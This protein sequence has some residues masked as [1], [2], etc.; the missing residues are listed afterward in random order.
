MRWI[1]LITYLLLIV[2]LAMASPENY[3]NYSSITVKVDYTSSIT[4]TSGDLN[5]LKANL[6]FFPIAEGSQ[7][8]TSFETIS[9]PVAK[10]TRED[11][12]IL[13]F[14]EENAPNF[15]YGYSTVLESKSEVIKIKNKVPYPQDVDESVAQYTLPSEFIDITSEMEDI[16]DEIIGSEDDLYKVV[17]LLAEWTRQNIEYDLTTLTADAVQKSSWVLENR[18]GV[19][20]ELTNLFISLARSRGIPARFT[21]G[22]VY[23]NSLYDFGPHGWAEVYIDDKWVPVDVTFG[24]MG[25]NDPDHIYF[26]EEVDSGESAVLYEWNGD[27]KIETSAPVINGEVLSTGKKVDYF[28]DFQIEPLLNGVGPGSY[29]PIQVT[30]ENPYDYYLPIKFSVTKAPGLVDDN[31]KIVL[32][33]PFEKTTVYWI[34][35]ISA[36]TEENYIYTTNVEIRTMLGEVENTTIT[37]GNKFGYSSLSEAESLVN[38]LVIEGS[39]SFLQNVGLVCNLDKDIYYS[40]ETALLSCDLQGHIDNISVCFRGDCKNEGSVLEWE[41]DLLNFKSQKLLIIAQKGKEILPEYIDLRIISYPEVSVVTVNPLSL[42]FQ[43]VVDLQ[44]ELL[45]TAPVYDVEVLLENYGVINIGEF[46]GSYIL[47]VPA[48]GKNFPYGKIILDISYSDELGKVYQ[49]NNVH[50]LEIT[51]IPIYYRII[52]WLL[53][54][55]SG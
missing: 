34:T 32:L 3:N 7:T 38:D 46:S 53:S 14:W 31:V 44:I 39:N 19:C 5:Y 8:I 20:D 37:Y 2:P 45:A 42:D 52:Y 48:S 12:S 47:K 55:F 11:N 6:F 17:W 24:I 50:D 27:A 28:V 35:T 26:R 33:E 25:W 22:L 13:Y 30:I 36:E 49:M 23:T 21:S 51:D 43:E 1:F 18:E 15:L 16:A 29:V 9:S 4:H 40:D 54:I 10:V 41:L